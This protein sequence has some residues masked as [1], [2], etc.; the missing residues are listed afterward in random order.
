MNDVC[1]PMVI[2]FTDPRAVYKVTLWIHECTCVRKNASVP[3]GADTPC[4]SFRESGLPLS[5]SGRAFPRSGIFSRRRRRDISPGRSGRAFPRLRIFLKSDMSLGRSGRAFPHP[6]IFSVGLVVEGVVVAAPHVVVDVDVERPVRSPCVLFE[7][8]RVVV[9]LTR[10][11]RSFLPRDI[12]GSSKLEGAYS[13]KLEPY[14][15]LPG[16][17]DRGCISS[18]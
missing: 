13:S 18:V 4:I 12:R 9:V 17:N 6:G 11:A 16:R 3:R 8:M 10:F 14:A 1:M 7:S 5:R 15:P 2:F